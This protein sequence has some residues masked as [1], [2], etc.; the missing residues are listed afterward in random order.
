MNLRE[1]IENH[2]WI[3]PAVV[4]G[5]IIVSVALEIFVHVY[6][7]ISV[8]YTHIFYLPI[9]IAGIWYYK[10]AVWIAL[11]FGVLHTVVEFFMTG[12]I[13]DPVALVRAA[14]FI[15][16]ACVVGS[17]SESRDRLFEERETKRLALVAFISEVALRIKTPMNVVLENL[18]EISRGLATGEMDKE[19]IQ[20]VLQIQIRHAE[21]ILATLRELNQG[22]IDEQKD[23]PD[24]YTDLLTR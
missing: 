5:L 19:E 6:L 7:N 1:N 18:G 2:P 21:T 16:V 4:I 3:K 9:V 17:L 15:L 10:K 12:V 8:A 20:V 14:M 11:F 13:F 23:I 24:S 22:V